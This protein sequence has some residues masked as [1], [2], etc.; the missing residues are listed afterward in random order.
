MDV[1]YKAL[2]DFRFRDVNQQSRN[3]VWQV[4]S[5]FITK[6]AG[7]PTRVLDPACGFGEF[8][9]SCPAS[10]RWASDLGMDGTSLQTGVKF[11]PGSFFDVDVPD[12][13][14]DLVFLSNV[15]EHMDN[16]Q[17]VNSFLV[18]A[19]SKLRPGGTVIVMGPNFKF[20][21]DEYFD[22]AD[23]SVI[24]THMSVEEHLA[25]AHFEIVETHPKFLPYS[26]RSRLPA[27][28]ITTKLY[29]NSKW[30]WRF[31]GKQFLVIAKKSN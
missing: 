20:C 23:H 12:E 16:Q 13:Y 15:L 3:N 14:F 18:Q 2:Y 25:S 26:F 4:I 22:C 7:S 9:N 28:R 5:P 8:I 30:A 17:M 29:L 24:L 6:K 21:A 11:L 27:T 10:E 19:F 1:D 31:L